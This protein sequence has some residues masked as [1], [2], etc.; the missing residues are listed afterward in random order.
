MVLH[1]ITRCDF[2]ISVI[3]LLLKNLPLRT[4][5]AAFQG[6]PA[7]FV[8]LHTLR[9][10]SHALQGGRTSFQEAGHSPGCQ[11]GGRHLVAGQESGRLQPAR[12][13]HPL[14]PV[15]RKVAANPPPI[16]PCVFDLK[17]CGLFPFSSSKTNKTTKR[18]L[19]FVFVS[20]RRLRYRMKMGSFPAP[21][22]PRALPCKPIYSLQLDLVYCQPA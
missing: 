3:F 11:P 14:H 5:S 19:S 18:F 22:S 17:V 8:Q 2:D 7:G 20:A 21:T 10:Q 13:A 6:L 15:P 12:C 4:L 16:N 1:F 9:G